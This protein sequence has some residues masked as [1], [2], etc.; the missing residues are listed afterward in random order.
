MDTSDEGRLNLELETGIKNACIDLAFEHQPETLAIQDA[1]KLLLQGLHEDVNRE[2]IK[3]TPF[4]VAKALREGTRGYKLKVKEYVQSAL[5][6]EA[7]LED[8]IGQ[9]GGVGGLVVVR[10]LDHY[11]YC[12][13][14]LLPFHVRCH[15]GYVPSE[16]RVLGLSK[17]SRVADVFAKR[18]QEPQGLADDIC[19]ALHHW[20]KPSGVAVVLQCSHIHFPCLDVKSPSDNGFVKLMVSSGSGVFDDEGSS[21]WGEFLSFLKLKGVKTE[22]LCGSVKKE[23]CPSVKTS[24]EEEDPEMVSAVVSILKSLGEDPS[25]EGLVATPSRFL[26]WM[27]NFQNVNLE[28]KLNGVNGVKANEKKKLHCELNLPFWSMCEH[29]LLPFYGV[30]HIGYYCGEGYNHKSLMKSIVHFYGFK[31]Q[32]QERMTRQIAETLSPLVGGDVIV[33]A[34]AGHTCMIS[35]GIEKFGSSTA[36]IAVL[37][38]FSN[39]GSARAE[40]LDKI[41]ATAAL[42]ADAS[43][44]F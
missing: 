9:A 21:L 26:K 40:F 22:A 32:V 27:M 25:R 36:T 10:D 8:G 1:V 4:R 31:L 11:S 29:H 38:Q 19:S 2:G 41:H 33:V 43:S 24:S 17:F 23:W 15:I 30:V 3:K 13:S 7:G 37:G 12:E 42:K 28:M 14:C 16:Q 35:R 5:F 34:E 39:D 44:P 18:L 20:V 6:P